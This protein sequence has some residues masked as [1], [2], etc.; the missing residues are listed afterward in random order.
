MENYWHNF[1]SLG[2][3]C[4]FGFVQHRSESDETSLFSCAAMGDGAT[5]RNSS[6]LPPHSTPSIIFL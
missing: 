3:N 2:D 5:R 4:E 6:D 1:Q